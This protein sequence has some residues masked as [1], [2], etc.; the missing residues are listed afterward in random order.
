MTQ[1]EYYNL[2]MMFKDSISLRLVRR[3]FKSAV[4][5]VHG[6]PEADVKKKLADAEEVRAVAEKE[7]ATAEKLRA[8]A[9]TERM[10]TLRENVK[11]IG[12]IS[13][14]CKSLG[15][16]DEQIKRAVIAP[17]L[18]ESAHEIENLLLPLTRSDSETV[19]EAAREHASNTSPHV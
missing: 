16:T 18:L 15:F 1:N 3:I 17:N 4:A 12:E 10:R 8:E 6:M 13:K 5:L 2:V 14:V 11:A 19:Y 9:A 7:K